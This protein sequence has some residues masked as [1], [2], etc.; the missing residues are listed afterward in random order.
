MITFSVFPP[1]WWAVLLVGGVACSMLIAFAW[2]WYYLKT[3]LRSIFR[4]TFLFG[5]LLIQLSVIV[6]FWP[7]GF[8]SQGLLIAWTWYV[9]WLTLRYYLS[10]Q[11]MDP[12]R[13]AYF[14]LANGLVM[15][16]FLLLLARW[17]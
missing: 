14:L 2:W 5:W 12:R 1:I 10:E 15:L 11:G 8:L 13:H 6:L 7:T 16:I 17:K 3:D 4:T 9:L